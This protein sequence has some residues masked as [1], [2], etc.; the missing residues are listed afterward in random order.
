MKGDAGKTNDDRY[1]QDCDLYVGPSS[2]PFTISSVAQSPYLT[3]QPA[4]HDFSHDLSPSSMSQ[5]ASR[6]STRALREDVK[7]VL[8]D[9]ET[10]KALRD[11]MLAWAESEE[12]EGGPSRK[13][14]KS[15][16]QQAKVEEEG[17]DI[18][19]VLDQVDRVVPSSLR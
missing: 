2:K 8:K 7:S 18:E 12:M 14:R 19:E 13:R 9:G 11:R 3:Q 16:R 15:K 17:D 5:L 6:C 1:D 10:I 4:Q